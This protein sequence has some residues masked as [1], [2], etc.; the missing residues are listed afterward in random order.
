MSFEDDLHKLE[1]DAT[2]A[3]LAAIPNIVKAVGVSSGKGKKAWQS[4]AR[5]HSYA[6]SYPASIDYDPV[7]LAGGTISTDLGPNL[8]RGVGTPGLGIVEDS[9]G[10]V[11]GSPQR[12]YAKAEA[13][14]EADLP[15]GVEIAID[16]ALR[17]FGL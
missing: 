9:P 16:Q 7:E 10:G 11:N 1:V 17:K 4:A 8:D 12:N 3:P 15:N 5:G 2:A 14:I 13:V 6:G